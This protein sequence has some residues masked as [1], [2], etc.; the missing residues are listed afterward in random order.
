MLPPEE[1][2]GIFLVIRAETTRPAV[3]AHAKSLIEQSG[4]RYL[5]ALLNR[6]RN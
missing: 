5:G 3:I 1:A 4:G 6:R 2:D